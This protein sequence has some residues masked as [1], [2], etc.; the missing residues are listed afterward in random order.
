MSVR[1]DLQGNIT[2]IRPKDSRTEQG[3]QALHSKRPDRPQN[4][5]PG[6]WL[7]SVL[8]S[9]GLLKVLTHSFALLYHLNL[10]YHKMFHCSTGTALPLLFARLKQKF[11]T[12]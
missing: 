10:D 7:L 8:V 3:V 2:C 1:H 6:T 12:Y 9:G 11:V 4:S 5:C